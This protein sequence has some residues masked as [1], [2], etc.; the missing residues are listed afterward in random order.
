MLP[1][2]NNRISV[3]R[4]PAGARWLRSL[5]V[6][7][8]VLLAVLFLALACLGAPGVALAD[9]RGDILLGTSTAEYEE[10]QQ[11]TATP[12]SAATASEGSAPLP[13]DIPG[14]ATQTATSQAHSP[15]VEAVPTQTLL[16][17]PNPEPTN[18]NPSQPAVT[19]S[20]TTGSMS[21]PAASATPSRTPYASSSPQAE[22]WEA[23][24]L[25]DFAETVGWPP[26]IVVEAGNRLS[27]RKGS[28]TDQW[29]SASIRPFNFRAG[30]TA[31]FA[32]EQEDARLAGYQLTQETFYGFPA[33]RATQVEQSASVPERRFR[34][35][36]NSWILGIDVRNSGVSRS[37]IEAN[38]KQLLALAAQ[39]GLPV[40]RGSVDLPTATPETPPQSTAEGCLIT[41][42]DVPPVMWAHNYI[43][44]LACTG[45]VSGYTDGLFRPQ[46]P[47]T[48]AQLVKM[49]VLLEQLSLER[50]AK[51][52]FADVGT[53]HPFYTYVETAARHDLIN[54]Y[55]DGTF[56]PDSFVSRAQV[57]KIVVLAR[58]WPV[59]TPTPT[60]TLCDVPS[61][62]WAYPYIQVAIARGIFTGYGDG[63]FHPDDF[64]TRAQL[65]K[66]LV[67]SRSR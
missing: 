43:T 19:P 61:K 6:P 62:H 27:V 9:E 46:N 1:P 42:S 60:A 34:W 33:Y 38:A 15:T 11:P 54:G 57:A 21:A 64:A 67:V 66:V 16:S 37:E 53:S 13:T 58:G 17:T 40:P 36:V 30:A 50:P 12:T 26:A 51:P 29:V 52:S 3:S 14:E 22:R 47:T 5:V 32:A 7:V 20:P 8:G 2:S 63:C 59:H 41:F 23:V 48:R 10:V 39:N 49:V 28:T 35:I 31:A 25:R 24:T 56:K 18:S 55:A 65:A 44:E 45:I 4:R